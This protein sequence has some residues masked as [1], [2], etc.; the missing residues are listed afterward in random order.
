MLLYDYSDGRILCNVYNNIVNR[1]HRPFG[2]INK[3]HEDTKR[4][5]RATENLRFF[6]A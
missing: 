2:L 5:F 1:S 4:T 3:I 6:A